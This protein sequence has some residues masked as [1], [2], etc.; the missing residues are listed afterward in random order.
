MEQSKAMERG[1]RKAAPDVSK[2]HNIYNLN[3]TMLPCKQALLEIIG[4][5]RVYCRLIDVVECLA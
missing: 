4:C 1:S 3:L 5:F 2:P